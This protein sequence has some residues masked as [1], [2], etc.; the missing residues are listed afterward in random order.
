MDRLIALFD[1]YLS[2]LQIPRIG[3]GDVVEILLIA[4]VIYHLI[5]WIRKTRAYYLLKGLVI[6]LAIWLGATICGFDAILWIFVN[7]INVGIIALIVIFQPEL[8]RAL[9]Q[10][11]SRNLWS[12]FD[13][14]VVSERFS[15]RTKRE[16][17]IACTEMAKVKTGALICIEEN[18]LLDEY[19]RTG[20]IIDSSISA[21]LIMNMFEK[22]TPL[23]DGAV[24]IRGDRVAAATCILPVSD[25]MRLSK[26][27]G[28]RHRAGVGISEVSDCFT[29]IVSEETGKISIAQKGQLIRNV[30]EEYLLSKLTECQN[31][32]THRKSISFRKDKKKHERKA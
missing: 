23:H 4:F 14:K 15:D 26:E 9:E 8:R 19:E 2:R 21:Q 28:T 27:L 3:I 7:T 18:V 10:L 25:N 31:K 32:V 12:F 30:D 22:N 6:L 24:L 16:L 17:V 5:N 11:G 13:N 29:I 20:I 1:K